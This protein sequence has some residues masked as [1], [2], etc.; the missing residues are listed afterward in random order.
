MC[1]QG[2]LQARATNA[3]CRRK[4]AVRSA[5]EWQPATLRRPCAEAAE[6]FGRPA[7]P[8]EQYI[9]ADEASGR[10]QSGGCLLTTL[11]RPP[12]AERQR[13]RDSGRGSAVL[14]RHSTAFE[15]RRARQA[16]DRITCV[17]TAPGF[18]ET[19]AT[20]PEPFARRSSRFSRSSA[21]SRA[22]SS[23]VSRWRCPVSRSLRRTD[24]RRRP[25]PLRQAPSLSQLGAIGNPGAVQD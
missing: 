16:R 24:C 23:V 17:C 7:A 25:R 3:A 11:A 9:G 21:L 12:L 1:R 18:P 2:E 4:G 20:A 13:L 14:T 15:W 6:M 8:A 19:S 5:N 22:C 10:C